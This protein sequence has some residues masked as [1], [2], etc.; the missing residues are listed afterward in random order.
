M[1]FSHSLSA[2]LLLRSSPL[3]TTRHF[4]IPGTHPR[5]PVETRFILH[6]SCVCAFYF[7]KIQHPP[8]KQLTPL[9]HPFRLGQNPILKT[10]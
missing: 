5:G 8:D 4:A 3:R 10:H 9:A 1:S 2:G 7:A 6:D